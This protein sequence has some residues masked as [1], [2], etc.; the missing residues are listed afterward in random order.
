MWDAIHVFAYVTQRSYDSCIWQMLEQKSRF[1]SQIASGNYAGRSA[2]DI[3]DLILTASMAKA[4]ALGNPAILDK[5]R[6]E[7]E[8]TQA[9]R[10]YRSWSQQADRSRREVANLPGEI[11]EQET[12]IAALRSALDD[13]R[14]PPESFT[15]KLRE[16]GGDRW[17]AFTDL[18]EAGM[19]LGTLATNLHKMSGKATVL[20]GE[21]RGMRLSMTRGWTGV[22]LTATHK[23]GTVFSAST[24]NGRSL[25]AIEYKISAASGHLANLVENVAMLKRRLAVLSDM[26]PMWSRREQ[27]AQ[28][29]TQYRS[30]CQA[31]AQEGLVDER[32]YH[33]GF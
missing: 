31:V 18:P 26:P 15:V 4:I 28:M 6:L 32:R 8:L 12:Q 21:Y 5:I 17:I 19:H 3:G 22:E 24:S 11:A 30:A 23:S 10:Q 1:I 25:A 29:L 14:T 27:V 20:V 7:T 33:F 13:L 9:E 2:D 16:I